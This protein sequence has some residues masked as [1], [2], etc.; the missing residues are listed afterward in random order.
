MAQI[1][2]PTTLHVLHNEHHLDY[3]S[4]VAIGPGDWNGRIDILNRG[5]PVWAGVLEIMRTDDAQAAAEIEAFLSAFE[6]R[7]NW[8]WLP[9]PRATTGAMNLTVASA[10]TGA[11]G[12]L[13]HRVNAVPGDLRTGM[14]LGHG[15]KMYSIRAIDR[16]GRSLALDPQRPIAAGET[17][18]PSTHVAAR[19]IETEHPP[20][21]RAARVW[22]PWTLAWREL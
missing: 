3:A 14:R 18:D 22:G 13:R 10:A 7:A 5:Y 8:A 4:Q 2:P 12:T 1:A 16:A 21:S 19:L 20:M 11:D 17:L 9:H 6:G 15:G